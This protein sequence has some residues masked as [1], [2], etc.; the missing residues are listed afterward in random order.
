MI[1]TKPQD[2]LALEYESVFERIMKSKNL[3]EAKELAADAIGAD[4][5]DYIEDEDFLD[6]E[7]EELDF[8]N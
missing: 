7:H 6:S 4:V 8:D 2:N 3:A 5:D 1:G